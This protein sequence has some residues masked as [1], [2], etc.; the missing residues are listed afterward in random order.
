MCQMPACA[1]N[2]RLVLF[3]QANSNFGKYLPFITVILKFVAWV[4]ED[5][6]WELTDLASF[7]PCSYG[8]MQRGISDSMRRNSLLTNLRFLLT[9]EYLGRCNP[10][11]KR[12]EELHITEMSIQ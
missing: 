4:A 5:P 9:R 11:N 1:L 6:S 7:G 2:E 3:P 8:N 12:R 10:K